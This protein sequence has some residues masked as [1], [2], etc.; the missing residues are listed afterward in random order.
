M[1]D[2]DKRGRKRPWPILRN[3]RKNL[4]WG[5]S[6]ITKIPLR[7]SDVRVK[8]RI[9]DEYSDVGLSRS[10]SMKEKNMHTES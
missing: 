6:K 4:P 7:I 9:Q 2:R 5:Q 1:A 8:N 3:C 10:C